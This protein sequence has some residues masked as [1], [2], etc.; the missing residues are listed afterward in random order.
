[1]GWRIPWVS[2]ANSDFS[3]DFGGSFTEEQV[4]AQMPTV[5]DYRH[6][7][8]PPI[9][10]HNATNTGTDIL[11]CILETPAVSVF[12]RQDGAAYQTYATAWRGVEFL[13]GYYPILDPAQRSRRGRRVP[14]LDPRHDEY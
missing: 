4:G 14:D 11:E 5:G 1:M 10:H 2:S 9:A 6:A 7:E 13:M 3:F 8:L 12:T